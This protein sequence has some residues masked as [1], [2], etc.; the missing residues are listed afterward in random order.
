MKKCLICGRASLPG[1]KLCA[2]CSSARKRAFAATVTQPLLAA[3][4]ARTGARLLKPSQSVAA[5]ARRTAERALSAKPD[6]PQ[7]VA[8]PST[9]RAAWMVAIGIAALVVTATYAARHVLVAPTAEPPVVTQQ[10][11]PLDAAALAASASATPSGPRLQSVAEPPTAVIGIDQPT[12]LREPSPAAKADAARRAATRTRTAPIEVPPPPAEPAPIVQT[13]VAVPAAA[14]GPSAQEAPRPDPWQAMNES[15]AR[16]NGGLL[17]RIV[18]DQRVRA[19]FCDGQ[20]GQVP[21]CPARVP[22]DHGQ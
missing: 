14:P 5:T 12:G 19:Q 18:C 8:A 13:L 9:R 2:D 4:G 21:Q 10:A 1:A 22:N 20:W 6:A 7:P 17:E 11:V 16:C 3:A 15:L